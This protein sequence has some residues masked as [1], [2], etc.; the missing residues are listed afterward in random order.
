M[1]LILVYS[2]AVVQCNAYARAHGLRPFSVYQ[3]RWSAAIRDFEREIIPMCKFEGMA[4][5]PWG[6]L[7]GGTINL[8][9]HQDCSPGGLTI[10][11]IGF[12]KSPSEGEKEGGRTLW[13]PGAKTESVSVVLDKIAK[14]KDVPITS[15][16]LAYVM[17]KGKYRTVT[18]MASN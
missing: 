16:G 9:F 13:L 1:S 8:S 4:L 14:K 18:T 15:V 12:F 3:G 6:A 11:I 7:G 10:A 2:W 17:H 5:A